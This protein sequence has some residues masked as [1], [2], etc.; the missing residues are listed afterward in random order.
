MAV[1]MREKLRLRRKNQ[2]P[3]K[4]TRS[5]NKS[6]SAAGRSNGHSAAGP[7]KVSFPADAI[8]LCQESAPCFAEAGPLSRAGRPGGLGPGGGRPSSQP[9]LPQQAQGGQNPSHLAPLAQTQGLGE[10]QSEATNLPP[11]R[12]PQSRSGP[13]WS[14]SGS[15]GKGERKGRYSG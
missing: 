13:C 14:S 15:L 2:N 5:Q 3:K 10:A 11:S 8:S 7:Q 4:P 9:G 6:A 12:P 1:L